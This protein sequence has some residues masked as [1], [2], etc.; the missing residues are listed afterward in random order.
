MS[1]LTIFLSLQTLSQPFCHPLL[2]TLKPASTQFIAPTQPHPLPPSVL[3][4]SP[5]VEPPLDFSSPAQF[6]PCLDSTAARHRLSV[7]P[8]NQR[9]STK[10]RLPAVSEHFFTCY[11]RC[12]CKH[13]QYTWWTSLSSCLFVHRLTLSLIYSPK[14]MMTTLTLQEKKS[15]A[16]RKRWRWK[17]NK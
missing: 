16:V 6:T 8:R 5:T 17:Q 14:T 9:A 3:S 7:K 12:E 15:L 4:N 10:R 13:T 1:F 11:I 2:P